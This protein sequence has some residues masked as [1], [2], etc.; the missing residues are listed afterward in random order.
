[1][2]D[3]FD[4]IHTAIDEH[5]RLLLLSGTDAM[6]VAN[7]L[8]QLGLAIWAAESGRHVEAESFLREYV[9]RRDSI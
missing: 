8:I 4:A 2:A 5:V 7:T 6:T 9:N 3:E 1:M